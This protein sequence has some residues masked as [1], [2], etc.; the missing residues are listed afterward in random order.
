MMK[1]YKKAKICSVWSVIPAF[2]LMAYI[3]GGPAVQ[4]AEDTIKIGVIGP[5]KYVQGIHHLA[6]AEIARD[7]IMAAG[8]I[9][10]GGKQ[11]KIRLVQADS[12]EIASVTDAVNAMERL[13][14]NEKVDFIVGGFR[15]EATLA[16]MEVNA[17]FKTIFLSCGPA[18]PDLSVQVAKNYN[19]YKYWFRGGPPNSISSA[20]SAFMFIEMV[21]GAVRKELG[22]EKPKIAILA[23]KALYI[24]PAVKMLES[25]LPNRG[26]EVVGTWRPSFTASSVMTELTAI[27][28]AGAQMIF[29][30]AAGSAGVAYSNQWGELKIPAAMFGLNVEAQRIQHWKNTEGR[31][32][33]L[34]MTA[35]FAKAAATKRSIPFYDKF[36]A[37]VGDAPTST[38][39]SYDAIW[40]L[41]DAIE[42]AGSLQKDAIVTA[43]EKTNFEGA[44]GRLVYYP[45]DHKWPHDLQWGPG[46]VTMFSVQWR[47]G[48][49]KVVWPDGSKAIGG[50]RYEGTVDYKLPPWMAKK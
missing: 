46:F 22:I 3:P 43:L 33:Y 10:V 23:D 13:I 17:D 8:G 47:D 1:R 18:S 37:K 11:Y 34:A 27:K 42:R 16:M 38:A 25:Q 32:A 48:E 7:E 20:P 19:R 30:Y 24:E 40:M 5:M 21:A 4:A 41:K 29:T 31:C 15:S 35:F 44:Q 26:L 14:A 12:N 6:A 36:V 45:N 28:A 39:S 2:I 9:S 50:V 49:M